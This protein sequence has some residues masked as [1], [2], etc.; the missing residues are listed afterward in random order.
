MLLMN[1][2]IWKAHIIFIERN[3]HI[4]E[5]RHFIPVLLNSQL[6]F[7][8]YIYILSISL[9]IYMYIHIYV[10]AQYIYGLPQ[11][12]TGKEFICNTEDA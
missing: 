10:Y 4:T 7:S 12:L 3:P 11:C 1:P 2:C 5:P 9:Y 8:L 6:S